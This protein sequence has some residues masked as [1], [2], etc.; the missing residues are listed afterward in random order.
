MS[1]VWNNN[2]TRPL[3]REER[4]VKLSVIK[5]TRLCKNLEQ[6]LRQGTWKGCVHTEKHIKGTFYLFLVNMELQKQ[7]YIKGKSSIKVWMRWFSMQ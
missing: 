4:E 5:T 6:G 1:E 7:S 3:G 2:W